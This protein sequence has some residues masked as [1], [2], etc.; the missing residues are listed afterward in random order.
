MEE[1]GR[2]EWKENSPD[3]VGIYPE[4]SCIVGRWRGVNGVGVGPIMLQKSMGYV[5]SHFSA[6]IY[7]C[8]SS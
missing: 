6:D 1:K 8:I 5:V 4:K 7:L 3:S 2:K